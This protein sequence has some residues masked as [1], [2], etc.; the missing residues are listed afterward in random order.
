MSEEKIFFAWFIVY[1]ERNIT[2]TLQVLMQFFLA[3]FYFLVHRSWRL[4]VILI[5]SLLI[6]ECPSICNMYI[7]QQDAQNS[8]D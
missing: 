3:T 2:A 4:P 5:R 7:I 6:F 8:C 1:A